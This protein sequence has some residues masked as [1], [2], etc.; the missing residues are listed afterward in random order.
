MKARGKEDA[1][2][3]RRVRLGQTLRTETEENQ[4]NRSDKKEVNDQ[5]LV[6][7]RKSPRDKLVLAEVEVEGGGGGSGGAIN[8]PK[9]AKYKKMVGVGVPQGA[10][11]V[12]M[13]KDGV[14]PPPGFFDGAGEDGGGSGGGGVGAPI[15]APMRLPPKKTEAAP[16]KPRP[17]PKPKP[18]PS[19]PKP[20]PKTKLPERTEKVEQQSRARP[21]PPTPT[22]YGTEEEEVEE[23]RRQ[24][25]QARPIPVPPRGNDERDDDSSAPF[26]KRLSNRLSRKGSK[27]SGFQNYTAG[28]PPGLGYSEAYE[29]HGATS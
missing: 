15:A 27:E 5:P 12:Q 21:L 7:G 4:D 10:V 6:E 14:T 3:R 2:G 25:A 1:A 29:R 28:P 20:K 13:K 9:Y 26:F 16:A 22:E 24:R 23:R 17:K 8:D 19:K 18:K 11:L